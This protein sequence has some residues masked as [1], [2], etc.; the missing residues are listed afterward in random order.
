MQRREFLNSIAVI[1]LTANFKITKKDQ[2]YIGK[3]FTKVIETADIPSEAGHIF[4]ANLLQKLANEYV[5][6]S[7]LG[8]IGFDN[9]LVIKISE[10]SHMI[11][12]LRFV[13]HKLLADIVL[14]NT[15]WGKRLALLNKTE[16]V[17]FYLAGQCELQQEFLNSYMPD[18]YQIITI[19]AGISPNLA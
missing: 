6:G 7:I 3:E 1:G 14:L 17:K 2:F 10:A 4:S 16:N 15:E 12:R 9:N 13:N 5:P 18:D 19:F 8:T 11:N